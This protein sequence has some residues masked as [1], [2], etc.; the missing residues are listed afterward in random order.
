MIEQTGCPVFVKPLLAG[1]N[2][3]FE[4]DVTLIAGK[5]WFEENATAQE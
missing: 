4:G 2:S 1:G 5:A 3:L